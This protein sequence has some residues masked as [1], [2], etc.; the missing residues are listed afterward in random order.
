MSLLLYVLDLEPLLRRLREE[1]A[2]P[3]VRRVSFAGRIRALVSAYAA[4]TTVFVSRRLD[5]LAEKKAIEKYEEVAG[6]KINFDK[7]E[8]LRLG[9]WREAVPLPGPFHWSNRPVRILGVW[10]GLDLQLERNW[11]KVWAKVEAQVGT[12]L[13]R[14]LSLKGRA[15]VCAE[16]IF[17]FILYHLSVLHLPRDQWR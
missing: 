15:E 17:L 7:S 8:G 1:E 12:W 13:R 5:I 14:Q 16:Y 2:T 4:D 11:S 6:A 9:A 10:F 3:A